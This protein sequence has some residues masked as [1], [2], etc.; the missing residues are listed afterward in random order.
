MSD[1]GIINIWQPESQLIIHQALGKV[2][3]EA[4]ELANAAVRCM[5]QGLAESE[6]VSKKPN[7]KM[8]QEE[9]SDAIAT[10]TWLSRLTGINI[11]HGRIYRKLAGYEEWQEGLEKSLQVSNS[12]VSKTAS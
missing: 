5:I 10:I 11:D 1:N 12:L 2:A 3:E 6:P 9:M 4:S 7:E 8:I